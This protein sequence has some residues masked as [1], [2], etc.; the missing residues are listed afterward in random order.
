MTGDTAKVGQ[1]HLVDSDKESQPATGREPNRPAGQHRSSISL[2]LSDK[3][4]P[5]P[6]RSPASAFQRAKS[7]FQR[8]DRSD[9]ICSA[10]DFSFSSRDTGSRSTSGVA[11]GATREKPASGNEQPAAQRAGRLDRPPALAAADA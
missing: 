7:P 6:N 1:T 2:S 11:A 4:V 9:R 10:V 5:T 3:Q 8:D